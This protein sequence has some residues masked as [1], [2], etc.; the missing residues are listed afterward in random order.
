MIFAVLVFIGYFIHALFDHED[1]ETSDPSFFSRQGNIR[2]FFFQGLIGYSAVNEPDCHRFRMI[3][4][5]Y[6]NGNR[7]NP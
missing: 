2:D 7:S 5:D 1:A 6:F 3:F 4:K